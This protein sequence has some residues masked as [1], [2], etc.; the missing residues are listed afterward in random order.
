VV[1]AIVETPAAIKRGGRTTL[2][3]VERLR[4]VDFSLESAA[5]VKVLPTM[6]G[7]GVKCSS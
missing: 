5:E 3:Q 4:A 6:M 2:G 7:T 1:E